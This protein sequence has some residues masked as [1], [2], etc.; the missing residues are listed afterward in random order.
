MFAQVYIN[1]L[2]TKVVCGMVNVLIIYRFS[3]LFIN[4][5]GRTNSQKLT[6]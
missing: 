6:I 1:V 3:K 2:V 4:F 5:A